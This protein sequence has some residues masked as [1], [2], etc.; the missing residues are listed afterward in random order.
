M[1]RKIIFS[2]LIIIAVCMTG[3]GFPDETPSNVEGTWNISI[4][5]IAGEATHKAVIE[6]DDNGLSGIYKGEFKEGT[7]RGR[8]EGKNIDFTGRL[9]HEA[10]GLSFHYTGTIEGDSMSG[11]VNLGEFWTATFTAKREKKK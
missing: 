5:F 2:G 1:L 7:L 6:Q 10:Q 11:T 4:K 8:V 3:S 9:K